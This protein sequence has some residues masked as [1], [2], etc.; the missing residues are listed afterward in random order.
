MERIMAQRSLE[1]EHWIGVRVKAVVPGSPK[2]S[3]R[4]QRQKAPW[5][6]ERG[7]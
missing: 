4:V 1:E 6:S 7:L 3:L 5:G 2:E